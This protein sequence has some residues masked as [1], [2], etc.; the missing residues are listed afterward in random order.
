M[1][2]FFNPNANRVVKA[3]GLSFRFPVTDSI[4]GVW[5]GVLSTDKPDELAALDA[6]IAAGGGIREITV[7]RFTQELESKKKARHT[8]NSP[9]SVP[10]PQPHLQIN[11]APAVLV[12]DPKAAGINADPAE[13]AGARV[14]SADDVLKIA[15]VIPPEAPKKTRAKKDQS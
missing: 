15:K 11:N 4:G 3:N 14:S 7:E 10:L 5:Q 6:V 2:Y 9:N 8:R 13:P 12:D 1:R